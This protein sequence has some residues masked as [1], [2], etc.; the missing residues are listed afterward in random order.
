[1]NRKLPKVLFF[2]RENCEFSSTVLKKLQDKKFHV[3][4]FESKKRGERLKNDILDWNGEFILCFRSFIKLPLSL[5]KKAK[6]AAINFHPAPPDYPGSGCIN[7]AL[8]D[9]A[10]TYGV[11]AHLMNEKIDNGIILDVKKF[12]INLNDNVQ[13]LLE[14]THKE[15]LKMCL[16]F[17]EGIS[18]NPVKFLDEKKYSSKNYKWNGNARKMNDL[19][20]LKKISTSISKNDLEKI[21]R[22]TYINN[23]PPYIELYGYKFYLHKTK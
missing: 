14:K 11:T 13:S 1:M 17:I 7:F 5:I 22:A 2:G 9:N 21:I 15:L 23:Y 6:I 19:D 16:K 18:S 10:K 3:T 12:P 4:Y 20:Q 8:Y